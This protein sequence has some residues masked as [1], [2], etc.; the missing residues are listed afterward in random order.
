MRQ[1]F[2]TGRTK[3]LEWRREQLLALRRLVVE[4]EE[5]LKVAVSSDLHKHAVESTLVETGMACAEIDDT[6]ANLKSWS[7]PTVCSCAHL[8][9]QQARH[10]TAFAR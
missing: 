6:L 8:S 3:S 4:N 9:R 7:K 10:H 5:A 1:A 2:G